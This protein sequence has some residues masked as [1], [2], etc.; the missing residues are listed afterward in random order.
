[1][2]APTVGD[3][4]TEDVKFY[5]S[6]VLFGPDG[7]E[8]TRYHKTHL[9]PF[10]EY[11]PLEP[12]FGILRNFVQIGRFSPGHEKTIFVLP[13]TSQKPHFKAR[14]GVLVCYEDIFPGLVRDFCRGGADFMINMT[15][16]AWFGKTTAPYQHAQA[17]VF[18]AVENRV[19]VIR[20]AN[21]GYS[22]FISPEGRILGA[23]ED[24]GEPIFVSGHHTMEILLRKN[25]SIFTRYGDLFLV[26][27]A[28][29][30]FLA[31]RDRP[32]QIPNL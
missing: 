15:N 19:N 4:E 28:G 25:T 13:S 27:V 32:G 22:C 1:V 30:C 21:T 12:L 11:I 20:S 23:V 9:V 8:R 6:A 16:D 10:G 18:R 24:K 7:E 31:Y 2:G 26:L 14:F 5:N 17:S 29:L 3:I